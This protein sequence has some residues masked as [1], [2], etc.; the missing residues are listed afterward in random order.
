MAGS[1]PFLT[2]LNQDYHLTLHRFQG[3]ERFHLALG[4]TG[5]VMDASHTG[6]RKVGLVAV[7]GE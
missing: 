7:P 3:A 5:R 6:Q 1:F 2:A 4:E